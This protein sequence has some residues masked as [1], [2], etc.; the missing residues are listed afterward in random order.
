MKTESL[1]LKYG[2]EIIESAQMQSERNYIQHGRT[3]VFEHSIGVAVL[4]LAAVHYLRLRV[5]ERALVRG[6]LLHDYFLYDW[7]IPE[8]YHRFHGFRHSRIALKNAVC[9]FEIGEIEKDIIEK[10]MFPLTFF[11]PR[12][13]ESILVCIVDKICAVLEMASCSY[14]DRRLFDKMVIGER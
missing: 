7:H 10:H 11:P 1:L 4:S 12:Y 3:T 2:K 5:D 13:R 6:A 9:D 14:Y 8:D